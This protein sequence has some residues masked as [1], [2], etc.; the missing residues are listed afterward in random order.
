MAV[1]TSKFHTTKCWQNPA[2]HSNFVKIVEV[3]PRDGL[4]NEKTIVPTKTKLALIEKLSQTG[5]SVI[6]AGA[7][8]SPKWVPQMADTPQILQY[9]DKHSVSG[10]Q[11]EGITYPY[12]VPNLQGL[13]RALGLGTTNLKEIAIFA[14]A[15][16]GF[17]QK[18]IN[19]S[20]DESLERFRPVLEL[21]HDRGIRV[22]GYISMI[23]S[24][25]YDG[26]TPPTRVA[27]VTKKLLD[28]GCYEVSLGDTNGTGTPPLTSVLLTTILSKPY[29]IPVSK[30]ACHFHDTYNSALVNAMTAL[31]LGVRTFDSSVAG[32]GGC[33]YS[34]GATGNVSTED[35][36]YFLHGMGVE[37]G[38]NL[39][40]VS[41]VGEW[42]SKELG[43]S[44]GS[45]VGPALL[46][47]LR[48]EDEKEEKE[49]EA[50]L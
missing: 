16:E 17:S 31:Y 25:P 42:I 27:E 26:P 20:I 9:L 5:L 7:F 38:V 19:C 49:K 3:G 11:S 10:A 41:R 29:A 28:M 30:L 48:T 35:L 46:T 24:C 1:D 50:E 45:K 23:F 6:E 13:E 18:N 39:E 34:K 36:T 8:V 33:P 2:L 40:G 37:T 15:S 32:L 44:N 22:R 14:S 47:R 21:C 43:R 4:Q 12:L